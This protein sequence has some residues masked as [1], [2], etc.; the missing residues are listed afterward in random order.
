MK[1][2]TGVIVQLGV[3][4]TVK[5]RVV[6]RGDGLHPPTRGQLHW[7]LWEGNIAVA[8]GNSERPGITHEDGIE[9]RWY[10]A[11]REIS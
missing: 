1:L 3:V 6:L 8:V 5:V 2:S 4:G 10:I 11:R 7:G 9:R